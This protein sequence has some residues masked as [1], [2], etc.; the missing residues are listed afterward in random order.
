MSNR[1]ALTSPAAGAAE[2]AAAAAATVIMPRRAGRRGAGGTSGELVLAAAPE[3]EVPPRCCCWETRAR[4][5]GPAEGRTE[6]LVATAPVA[7]ADAIMA[8]QLTAVSEVNRCDR[9]WN[10]RRTEG[11]SQD[12][13]SYFLFT[14]HFSPL[15]CFIRTMA[16]ALSAI[17]LVGARCKRLNALPRPSRLASPLSRMTS[18]Y[19]TRAGSPG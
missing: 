8:S 10:V 13:T 18:V 12:S 19:A 4:R 14:L 7:T 3:L 1:T 17:T 5:G 6:A 15:T 2:A 11:A 16:S 9:W